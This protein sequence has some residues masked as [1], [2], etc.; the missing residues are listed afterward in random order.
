MHNREQS[1]LVS[2]L[3]EKTPVTLH[4]RLQL[5]FAF[6]RLGSQ[7][8]K[9]ANAEPGSAT[10]NPADREKGI[11]ELANELEALLI[12][13]FELRDSIRGPSLIYLCY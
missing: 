12:G 11:H 10:C 7:A 4:Q 2:K 9:R 1:E 3:R 5:G 8:G 6:V 13:P